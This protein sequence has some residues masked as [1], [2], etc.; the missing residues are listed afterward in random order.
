MKESNLRHCERCGCWM[1]GTQRRCTNCELV[2]RRDKV[3]YRDPLLVL[4]IPKKHHAIARQMAKVYGTMQPKNL[5]MTNRRGDVKNR[6]AVTVDELMIEHFGCDDWHR[7]CPQLAT[8]IIELGEQRLDR[9]R[10]K[11]RAGQHTVS[12]AA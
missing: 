8:A 7:V 2:A 1:R 10:R 9:Q 4:D 12:E 6:D 5:P 3:R 11:S